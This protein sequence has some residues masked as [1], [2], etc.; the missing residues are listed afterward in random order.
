MR[1]N[2]ISGQI[3]GGRNLTLVEKASNRWKKH[4]IC[5]FRA[6]IDGRSLKLVE[7]FFGTP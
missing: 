7:Y 6:Q 4:Q 2:Q 3:G 1:T 5:G